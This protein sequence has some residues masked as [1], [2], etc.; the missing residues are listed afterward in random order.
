MTPTATVAGLFFAHPEARYFM[1]GHIS[2]EQLLDY[3]AR[4]H[5]PADTVRKF[6]NKNI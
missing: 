1:I 5:E 2:D 6:L 4:R 3:A